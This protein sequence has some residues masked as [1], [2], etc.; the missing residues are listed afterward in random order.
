MTAAHGA[1]DDFPQLLRS[2]PPSALHML[3]VQAL[4]GD[5]PS[6][7]ALGQMYL[8]GIGCDRNGAEARYWF[9][10]AAHHGEAMAMNMLGRCL[11]NGWGGAVDYE[12]AVV[13]YRESAEH[14]SDW[15]MYNYAHVL[16][17]GRGVKADRAAAFLW[18]SRAAERGHGRAMHFLGQ[19]YEFGWETEADPERARELYRLSAEKGDYRGQ[20]SW[21][22]V[23]TEQ[24]RIDEACILLRRVMAAAPT[25]FVEALRE[26]LSRS[27]HPQ[28]RA[29]AGA[30]PL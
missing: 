4:A 20:C 28:L 16:A 30:D 10:H 26:D 25:Y 21:A 7:L 29:L 8:E 5:G 13:W 14:G 9:Q 12:L 17:Q 2:D 22:S 6:Q 23:L 15:G 19:Y 1:R 3:R 27:R 18:F 11:E 24:G